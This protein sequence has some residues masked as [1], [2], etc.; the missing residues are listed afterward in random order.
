MCSSLLHSASW[1]LGSSESS[2]C[3]ELCELE[4]PGHILNGELEDG[5]MCSRSGS[6][7]QEDAALEEQPGRDGSPESELRVLGPCGW[8]VWHF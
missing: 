1:V 7:F 4:A 6:V 5:K 2:P 8:R 3:Q